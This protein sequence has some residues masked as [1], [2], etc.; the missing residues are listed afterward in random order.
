MAKRAIAEYGC[1]ICCALRTKNHDPLK[2]CA[3]CKV[4]MYCS[5]VCFFNETEKK[6]EIMEE[7]PFDDITQL[8]YGFFFNDLSD[9][10]RD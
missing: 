9:F 4:A 3:R 7:W 5:K 8:L 10:Y 1:M 2:R 6:N